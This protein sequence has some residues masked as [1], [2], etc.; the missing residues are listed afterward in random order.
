MKPS[1][2]VRKARMLRG[3]AHDILKIR[4]AFRVFLSTSDIN[5]YEAAARRAD[6]IQ[7]SMPLRWQIYLSRNI[8]RLVI[9]PAERIIFPGIDGPAR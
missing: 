9:H 3:I 4:E 6:T 8:S 5:L 1:R 7:N 2:A